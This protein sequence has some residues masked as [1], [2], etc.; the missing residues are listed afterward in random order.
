MRVRS[1]KMGV[2]LWVVGQS[3]PRTGNRNWSLF[4]LCE[5]AKTSLPSLLLYDST[6][7]KNTNWFTHY[8]AP[9]SSND[10]LVRPDTPSSLPLGEERPAAAA[11]VLD[12]L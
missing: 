7:Y 5:G 11:P 8:L 12:V 4:Y 3:L 1:F 9:L 10:F 6:S 2:Y